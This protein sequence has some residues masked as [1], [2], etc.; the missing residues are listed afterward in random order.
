[1]IIPSKK[2][3]GIWPWVQ[4]VFSLLLKGIH[5]CLCG[6]FLESSKASLHVLTWLYKYSIMVW[7]NCVE[8][9]DVHWKSEWG[10]WMHLLWYRVLLFVLWFHMDKVVNYKNTLYPGTPLSALLVVFFNI[11]F[12]SPPALKSMFLTSNPHPIVQEMADMPDRT[13]VWWGCGG[14]GVCRSQLDTGY[15][16][17]D[18]DLAV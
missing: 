2:Q 9:H 16:P 7:K 10:F 4:R 17:G 6:V 11:S 14:G 15:F 1:M 12:R 3:A 5:I 13:S 8:L 18:T